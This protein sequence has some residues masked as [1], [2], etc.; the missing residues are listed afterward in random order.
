MNLI[1][2][3]RSGTTRNSL[4]SSTGSSWY[5]NTKRWMT[6]KL[7]TKA[8]NIS[9]KSSNQ[10]RATNLLLAWNVKWLLFDWIFP[11]GMWSAKQPWAMF[12]FK[13]IKFSRFPVRCEFEVSTYQH[14]IPNFTQAKLPER[15]ECILYTRTRTLSRCNAG[16]R[17]IT[18]VQLYTEDE[19]TKETQV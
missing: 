8:I 16:V 11:C 9:T 10:A 14:R 3:G 6:C 2:I 7:K 13:R 4:V 15:K 12:T 18:G 5:S 19:N 17:V 1:L